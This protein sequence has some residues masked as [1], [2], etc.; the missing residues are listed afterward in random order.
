MCSKIT[1]KIKIFECIY[2][3]ADLIKNSL[4][5]II[6]KSKI[7]TKNTSNVLNDVFVN[8][9][10]EWNLNKEYEYFLEDLL[11]YIIN[12]TKNKL[13]ST[14]YNLQCKDC[15]GVIYNIGD[16]IL[17]HSH[18]DSS[19]YSFTYYVNAPKGSSPLVFPEYDYKIFP[20]SGKLIIFDSKMLH[21]IPKNMCKNRICLVGNLSYV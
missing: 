12:L 18:S 8:K 5:D 3:H 11:E 19:I 9:M 14:N 17:P 20:S 6:L 7:K 1:E 21:E 16:Y 13:D 15:W 10:T 2:E 4:I